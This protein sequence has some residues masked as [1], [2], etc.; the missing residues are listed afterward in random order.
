MHVRSTLIILILVFLRVI[1]FSTVLI[2]LL[3]IL[4]QCHLTFV[5]LLS[6]RGLNFVKN[7]IIALI[8]IALTDFFTLSFIALDD[9][10]YHF[11][12]IIVIDSSL[13]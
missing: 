5:R 12:E 11:D 8:C 9:L 2:R 13:F 7:I 4:H 6:K 10:E 1:D 3:I